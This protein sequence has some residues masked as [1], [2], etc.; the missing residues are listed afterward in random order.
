MDITIENNHTSCTLSNIPCR[1][2][3]KRENI[4]ITPAFLHTS[5]YMY[6]LMYICR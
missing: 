4:E 2:L 5:I 1:N 3:H 6:I